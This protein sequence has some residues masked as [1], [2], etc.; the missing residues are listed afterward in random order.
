MSKKTALRLIGASQRMSG[1]NILEVAKLLVPP[2]P[3]AGAEAD[4][5]VVEY[6]KHGLKNHSVKLAE[7]SGT[8]SAFAGLP[9]ASL[10]T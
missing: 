8:F 5:W 2:N 9:T 10:R 4:T 6:R 3:G 7:Q 1:M